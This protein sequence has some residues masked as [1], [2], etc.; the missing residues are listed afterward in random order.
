MIDLKDVQ[1]DAP[2]ESKDVDGFATWT[3][4]VGSATYEGKPHMIRSSGGKG[5]EKAKSS[6]GFFALYPEG[7]KN[8]DVYSKIHSSVVTVE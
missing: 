8:D 3:D 4:I 6:I 1:Q 2:V 7:D 5:T